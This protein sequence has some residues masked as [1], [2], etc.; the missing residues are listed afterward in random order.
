MVDSDKPGGPVAVMFAAVA[1][2]ARLYEKHGNDLG[3]SM[4][5]DCLA[6]M[7]AIT[8][9]HE[10]RIIKTVGEEIICVFTD[11]SRCALAANEMQEAVRSVGQREATPEAT[12]RAR[13]GV[14]YGPVIDEGDDVFGDTVNTAARL[15]S[16]AKR[17]R[18]WSAVNW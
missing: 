18:S 17:R 9:K 1:D 12:L 5:S 7:A 6:E 16:L 2:P 13:I 4:V 3:W 14:H 11:A 8:R 10:G 15:M